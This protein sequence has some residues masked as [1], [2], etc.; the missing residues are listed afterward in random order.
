MSEYVSYN[1]RFYKAGTALVEA[2]NRGLRYGDG[3]FETMRFSNGTIQ[4]MDAHFERLFEG[5]RLL[6]F[7]IPTHFTPQFLAANVATLCK[8]NMHTPARVRINIIRGNGG[9]YDAQNHQ[10]HCI[11]E[12]WQLAAPHFEL[13]QN[14]LVTGIYP[15]ARK[16]MDSF[17]HCK[18]NNY[19]PY[20][21]AALYA[22]KHRWN[23]AI[24][25]NAA[26][27][28]CDATIANIFMVS[29][30]T[31]YTSPLSEGCVAGVMRK[32]LLQKLPTLGIPV[33]EK[34]IT[35]ADLLDAD[36]LFLTNAVKGIRWVS[37]CENATYTRQL[38]NLIFDKLLK[39]L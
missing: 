16:A 38:T 29:A 1:G 11:I 32:M 19:L 33:T 23:D 26:D 17:S 10:P 14:G 21:M 5:L 13:N 22:Q 3:L 8:K 9:L 15:H 25:L 37:H 27:R 35:T 4:Q 34:I 6:G 7:D 18:H 28:V 39:N 2:G 30:G 20:T 31:V 36:E 24:L 12:S